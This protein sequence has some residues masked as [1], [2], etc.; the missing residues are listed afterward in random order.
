M[1]HRIS[2]IVSS[3]QDLESI[4]ARLGYRYAREVDHDIGR[5]IPPVWM[6]GRDLPRGDRQ[7]DGLLIEGELG[8]VER[9]TWDRPNE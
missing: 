9:C 1:L 8:T 7:D 2:S 6:L 3:D 5:E 4:E